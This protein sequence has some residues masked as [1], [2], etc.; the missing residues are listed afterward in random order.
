MITK[1]FKEIGIILRDWFTER[2]NQSFC[3]GRLIA[4]FASLVLTYKFIISDNPPDFQGFGLS[5]TG[6]IAFV[7]VKNWTEKS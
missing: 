6:I 2:D 5:I 7:A 3:I 1:V 4:I